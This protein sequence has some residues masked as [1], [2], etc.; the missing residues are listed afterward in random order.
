[1]ALLLIPV[2]LLIFR[3]AIPGHVRASARESSL[4]SLGRGR[5]LRFLAQDY[6]ASIFTQATLTILPFIV[7]GV[8][9]ARESAYFAMPFTIALAFDTFAYG[10]CSSLVVEAT[11][12]RDNLRALARLFARRVL[13]VVVLAA[14]LLVLAAPLL[15]APF[16]S[17]YAQHGVGAL[18]LL[19]CAS[20]FRVVIALFAAISRVQ[21]RG[22]RLAALEFCLMALVVAPAAALARD[23]GIEGVALGWLAANAIVCAAAIPALIRALGE[24]SAAAETA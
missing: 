20:V 10:A 13:T 7:I 6:L 23:H 2:N 24:R 3:R 8:L 17:V 4:S 1:M 16:G 9:G 21:G 12:D 14:G 5:V 22:T 15:M 18:R 19:I 11:L